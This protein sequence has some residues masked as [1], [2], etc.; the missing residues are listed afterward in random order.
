MTPERF[1]SAFETIFDVAVA[2]TGYAAFAACMKLAE[3]GKRVL[4]FDGRSDLLWESGRAFSPNP[5]E[6]SSPLWQKLIE[7]TTQS[8][9]VGDA[10]LDGGI[11]ETVATQM[12]A[13]SGARVLYYAMPT[14]VEMDGDSIAS[15]LVATKNGPRRVAA[16][17]YIDATESALLARLAN[18][19]I[20]TKQASSRLFSIFMQRDNWPDF[21]AA[22][23]DINGLSIHDT[24]W[25]GEK[26]FLLEY[27]EADP[28]LQ[29]IFALIKKLHNA[30]PEIIRK[31][32]LSHMSVQTYPLYDSGAVEAAVPKN[33]SLAA[34]GLSAESITSLGQRLELGLR[35]VDG[36]DKKASA[37]I[38][39]SIFGKP[40]PA[41]SPKT[42]REFDV[43]VIG[44]GTGGAFAGIAAGRGFD[45]EPGHVAVIEPMAFPGGI[46]TGG[47]IYGYYFGIPG[48]MQ[49]EADQRLKAIMDDYGRL[50][51]CTVFRSFHPEAK[52]MLLDIMLREAGC[53][54]FYGYMPYSVQRSNSRIESA[55]IAGPDGPILLKSGGWIDGTGDG[56]FSVMAGA[57]HHMGRRGDALVHAYS[58]S[59]GRLTEQDGMPG[60]RIVNYD[61]GWCDS[62]DSE[63]MSRARM[64]GIMQYLGQ[65][66]ENLSR[67][68]YICPAIGLR[69]GRH[70][71]TDYTIT[72]NDQIM[73]RRFDD[74]I[75]FAACHYDN[76]ATDLELESDEAVFWM[77]CLRNSRLPVACEI[78]YRA[79]LP[80]GLDNLWVASRCLGVSQDAHHSLR[81][82]RDMQRIGEATGW[83]AAIAVQE[84]TGS[85]DISWARL[86]E[87][88]ESTGALTP[89]P[90]GTDPIFSRTLDWQD[91]DELPEDAR[92]EKAMERL[93]AGEYDPAIWYLYQARSRTE[94][95]VKKRLQSDKPVTTWLAACVCAMWKDAS[96]EARMIVAIENREGLHEAFLEEAR[97][98]AFKMRRNVP[99]WL[100]AVVMLRR[101]GTAKCLPALNELAS[102]PRLPLNARTAIAL[103]IEE[104]AARLDEAASKDAAKVLDAL[105]RDDLP[106]AVVPPQ[107]AIGVMAQEAVEGKEISVPEMQT[108]AEDHR[109]QLALTILRAKKALGLETRDAA[110]AWLSDPRAYVRHAF[111]RMMSD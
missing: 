33:L 76:H 105:E 55:I 23:F 17:Q 88:L 89:P 20:Q 64:T 75:G 37:Q 109:W 86:K 65:P 110:Q 13:N 87:R 63:D 101:C 51:G 26:R 10:Y 98:D 94:A 59:S 80:K 50:F 99:Q 102:T 52:K 68:T 7:K 100:A 104:I 8:K 3:Q 9:G 69:Q 46:G 62:S 14:A 79:L 106:D 103:T 48:G 56:D 73:H 90:R 66:F 2:G 27:S 42:T 29:D 22:D 31:A 61:A 74:A 36:L 25:P 47:G 40:L 84:K 108:T 18:N 49:E 44:A 85:R 81:M 72:L 53:E 97:R 83:A 34:P 70:I 16:R 111:A 57:D 6:S 96:A 67:P 15:I 91:F 54:M 41:I 60:I 4:M 78:P 35:A 11:V 32:A 30:Q 19:N 5:G 1:E 107:R 38:D 28:T 12:L 24:I 92:I 39:D 95:D 82:M 58:Q 21:S 93:D 43:A 45:S 77:W 71:E